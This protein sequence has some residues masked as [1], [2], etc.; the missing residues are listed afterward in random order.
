[1]HVTERDNVDF[2]VLGAHGKGGP[3][4][5]QVRHV[6]WEV[7]RLTS[8]TPTMVVPPAPI[9]SVI[10]KQYVFVVAVDTSATAARCINAALKLM[11]PVDILR[12]VHFYE[13][14]IVGE[15]DTQPFEW[16][17]DI[18]K[19]AQVRRS[20]LLIARTRID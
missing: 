16:Y 13:R 6:P 8:S 19:E 3:A 2:L 10:S 4:I 17:R 12:V 5:D 7:L 1:L 20:F 9:N 11:R 14:P 15:F 18:M